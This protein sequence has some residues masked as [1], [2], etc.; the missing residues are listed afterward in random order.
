MADQ[1]QS[2]DGGMYGNGIPAWHGKGVVIDGLATAAECLKYA[3]L[4]WQVVKEPLAIASTGVVVSDKVATVRDDDKTVLGYVSPDYEILQNNEIFDV[5]DPICDKGDAVYETA[6]SLFGGRKIYVTAKVSAIIRVGKMNDDE[7]HNYLLATT[8][9]DGSASTVVKLINNRVV[10]NNTLTAALAEKGRDFK[11]RHTS[12]SKEKLDQAVIALGLANAKIKE[13]SE[14]YN[15]M[16]N[17]AMNDADVKA[18]LERCFKIKTVAV[19]KDADKVAAL[20]E[21]STEDKKKRD[22]YLLTGACELYETSPTVTRG[23][24]WGAF[25]AMT[26]MVNHHRRDRETS[27]GFSKEDN[28]LNSLLY[29]QSADLMTLGLVEAQ[30]LMRV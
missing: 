30:K 16:A 22:S 14:V 10:C 12:K 19:S 28:K 3:K 17:H 25:N 2:N 4:D 6:G 8:G 7:I 5:F 24:L 29:G 21:E 11:L 27:K 9:H 23:N 13:M 1:I 18:F 26:E 15:A 20:L